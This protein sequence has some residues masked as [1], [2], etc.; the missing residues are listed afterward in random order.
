MSFCGSFNR[1]LN[2]GP[3]VR[4]AIGAAEDRPVRRFTGPG[5]YEKPEP[6]GEMV[7]CSKGIRISNNFSKMDP[8]D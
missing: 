7:L 1:C 4:A 5:L 6:G 8:T 3:S 2:S